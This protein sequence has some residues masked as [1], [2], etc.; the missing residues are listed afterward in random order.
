MTVPDTDAWM[1]A[2]RPAI[3]PIFWP[4]FTWSPTETMGLQGAPTCIA[5]AMTT[6]LGAA[7]RGTISLWRANS[8][9]SWGCTPP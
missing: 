2:P 1:G 6:S 9:R 4:T 8:F 5:M 3:S 7:L